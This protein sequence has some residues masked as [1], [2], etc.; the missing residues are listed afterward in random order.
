M[1]DKTPPSR[2]LDKFIIRL[3]DGMRERL[4][5]AASQAGRST[6]AEIVRRLERS[7]EVA[8]FVEDFE[9]LKRTNL[10]QKALLDERQRMIDMLDRLVQ[11]Q[12]GSASPA[13]AKK[14]AKPKR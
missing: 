4:A 7:F 3:P 1:E 14:A 8:R 2:S 12:Q 10:Q 6:T 9:L 5:E 13:P 11:A